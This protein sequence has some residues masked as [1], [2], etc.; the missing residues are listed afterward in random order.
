MHELGHI[1]LMKGG[2]IA[3]NLDTTNRGCYFSATEHGIR[4]LS[5]LPD[6]FGKNV[7]DLSG[8]DGTPVVTVTP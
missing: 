4:K 3:R 6:C 2:Q 5:S 8:T 1:G 7:Y